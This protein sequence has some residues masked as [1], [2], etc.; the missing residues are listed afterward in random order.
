MK[1]LYELSS[2]AASLKPR[3]SKK[4]KILS[5]HKDLDRMMHQAHHNAFATIDCLDCANCCKTTSPLFTSSD[6]ER[7]A[8][9]LQLRPAVFVDRYLKVDEDGD[10]VLKSV[11]CPFLGSDN[12]CSVYEARPKACRGYPHTDQPRQRKILSLAIQNASICPA[13]LQILEEVLDQV[14]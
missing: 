12:Y 5:Q 7:L 11:P 4:R 3:F 2:K 8:S 13:V 14:S 1:E 6:I 9:H 10:H